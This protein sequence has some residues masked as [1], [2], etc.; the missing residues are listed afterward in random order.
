MTAPPETSPA[1]ASFAA[2]CL[3][4]CGCHDPVVFGHAAVRAAP[5]AE[6]ADTRAERDA[7]RAIAE[8]DR[9]LGFAW[10]RLTS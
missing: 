9:D 4:G 2:P 10:L 6:I 8:R 3:P 5:Y 1:A 7:A